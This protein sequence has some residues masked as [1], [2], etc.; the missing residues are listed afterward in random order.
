MTKPVVRVVQTIDAEDKYPI[1]EGGMIDKK[2]LDCLEKAGL[3][4]IH[5]VDP[6][7]L[8]EKCFDI[9]C[10]DGLLSPGLWAACLSDN[11][12]N[13]GFNAVVAPSTN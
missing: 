9:E 2:F 7:G 5:E 11:L 8:T 12:R 1:N 4:T 10:P 13:C 3:I 6:H